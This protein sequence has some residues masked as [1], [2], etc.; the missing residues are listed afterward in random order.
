MNVN[1]KHFS[2]NLK[3]N[4]SIIKC[5][6]VMNIGEGFEGYIE[7]LYVNFIPF[8]LSIIKQRWDMFLP[9]SAL[10]VVHEQ[11]EEVI[12]TDLTQ[13]FKIPCPLNSNLWNERLFCD[14]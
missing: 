13:T 6:Q 1:N 4:S 10:N 3:C 2:A 5:N 8:A 12:Y 11:N 14:Y 7:K 9:Y